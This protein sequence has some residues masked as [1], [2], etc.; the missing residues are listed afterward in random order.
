MLMLI[1][2]CLRYIL[3]H[4]E[5]YASKKKGKVFKVDIYFIEKVTRNL[6]PISIAHTENIF[7]GFVLAE[8]LPKPTLVKLLHVKYKAVTYAVN[9][10][11]G[12][13][14]LTGCSILSP[15]SYSQPMIK[16][17]QTYG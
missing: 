17:R 14:M 1:E 8:T 10:S 16:K 12:L 13:D 9:V 7:S 15:S 11:G 5:V 6:P 2:T 4:E 3:P